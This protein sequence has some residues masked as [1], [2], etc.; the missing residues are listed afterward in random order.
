[1]TNIESMRTALEEWSDEWSTRD[2]VMGA[3]SLLMLIESQKA[4]EFTSSPTALHSPLQLTLTILFLESMF[5]FDMVSY[6]R[7]RHVGL[8]SLNV[9]Y[10]AGTVVRAYALMWARL[11][12]EEMD[13]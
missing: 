9:V 8:D 1:M 13:K 10:W 11:Q 3:I 5:F 6:S 2:R 4:L 12:M 7:G